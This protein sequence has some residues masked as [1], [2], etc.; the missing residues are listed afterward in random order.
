[1]KTVYDFTVKDRLGNDVCLSDYR[2]KV[3]EQRNDQR[4]LHG[5]F[6]DVVLHGGMYPFRWL[7]I[8]NFRVKRKTH[9]SV[10]KTMVS[11]I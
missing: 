8:A 7:G 2:G 9:E 6:L 11:C 5:V 10:C 3:P 1:M 4:L